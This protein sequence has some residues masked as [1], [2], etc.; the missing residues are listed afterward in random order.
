[1]SKHWI[2]KDQYYR[3]FVEA[4]KIFGNYVAS[5]SEEDLWIEIFIDD[6][7]YD[8]N[9]W[10]ENDGKNIYCT[11]HPTMVNEKGKVETIG[12]EFIRMITLERHS[13]E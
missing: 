6:E 8:L 13:Y 11:I 4:E 5:F 1:M 10:E 2:T 12:T 3:A 9:I 7:I